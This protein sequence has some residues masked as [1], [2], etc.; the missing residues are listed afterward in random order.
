MH[1]NAVLHA[2]DFDIMAKRRRVYAPTADSDVASGH[3]T[4]H[5]RPPRPRRNL[6]ARPHHSLHAQRLRP[7]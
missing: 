1:K 2:D 4:G 7:P 5:P 6:H 3:R